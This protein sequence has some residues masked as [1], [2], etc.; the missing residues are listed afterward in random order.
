[1]SL[2][3]L[4]IQNYTV[5]IYSNFITISKVLYTSELNINDIKANIIDL[6]LTGILSKYPPINVLLFK[7]WEGTESGGNPHTPRIM[8]MVNF[9]S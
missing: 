5:I 8:F 3:K 9:K 1:M 6:N 7:G 4:Y 2:L